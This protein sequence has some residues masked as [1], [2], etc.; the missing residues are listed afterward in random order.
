MHRDRPHQGPVRPAVRPEADS[1]SRRDRAAARPI[2]SPPHPR[3]SR[4][5]SG[6]PRGRA[7]RY[8]SFRRRRAAHP[9]QPGMTDPLSRKVRSPPGSGAATWAVRCA[10]W[11]WATVL[12]DEVTTV[13]VVARAG[14]N[15]GRSLSAANRCDADALRLQF[16]ASTRGDVGRVEIDH[17]PDLRV[18]RGHG[19]QLVDVL[20]L[21]AGNGRGLG[22]HERLVGRELRVPCTEIAGDG[23]REARAG[24]AVGP[25]PVHVARTR[26]VGAP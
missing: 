20:R 12:S 7:W 14:W 6:S 23:R 5:R 11:P 21:Q 16:V 4:R 24:V 19:G 22:D 15:E 25:D 2:R 9:P 1:P 13:V 17:R 10:V 3:C 26:I 8:H 18:L